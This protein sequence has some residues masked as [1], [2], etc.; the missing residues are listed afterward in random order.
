MSV[1]HA[2]CTRHPIC[3]HSLPYAPPR[4]RAPRPR[5]DRYVPLFGGAAYDPSLERPDPVPFEEQL[6]GLEEVVRAGKVGEGKG[7]GAGQRP[8]R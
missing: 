5:P 6:R 1:T 2:C 7:C 8:G 3:F 4:H